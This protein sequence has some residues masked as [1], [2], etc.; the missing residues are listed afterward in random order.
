MRTILVSNKTSLSLLRGNLRSLLWEIFEFLWKTKAL[1]HDFFSGR[2]KLT[3]LLETKSLVHTFSQVIIMRN[4]EFV[5][6]N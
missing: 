1:A 2:E 3:F 6:E 4:F 5:R